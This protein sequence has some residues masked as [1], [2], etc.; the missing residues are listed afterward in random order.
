MIVKRLRARLRSNREVRLEIDEGRNKHLRWTA[1]D[2]ETGQQACRSVG[3][4]FDSQAEAIEHA[5]DYMDVEDE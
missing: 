1:I 2:V 5:K 4:R 3:W